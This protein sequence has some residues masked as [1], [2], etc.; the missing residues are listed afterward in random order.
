M[1]ADSRLVKYGTKYGSYDIL[2]NEVRLEE[3][4]VLP[5]DNRMPAIGR[6]PS[7]AA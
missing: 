5:T 1:T 6:R 3:I 4:R 7:P 2:F